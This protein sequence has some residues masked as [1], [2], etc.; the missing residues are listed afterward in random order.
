REAA[1]ALGLAA[2]TANA[3]AATLPAATS[4]GIARGL[5]ETAIGPITASGGAVAS[6]TAVASTTSASAALGVASLGVLGKSL[7]GG[8]IVSFVALTTLDQTRGASSNRGRQVAQ[9]AS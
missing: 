3:L 2:S 6:G 4:L 9:S 5:A 1:L 7:L 8:A